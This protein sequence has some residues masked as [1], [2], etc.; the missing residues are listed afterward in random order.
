[1]NAMIG[2]F[3]GRDIIRKPTCPFCGAVISRPAEPEFSMPHDLPVG[4]C[5]CGATYAYDP[6]G[7]N[8]GIAMT[9]ALVLACGGD[10]DRAWDLVPDQDYREAQVENYDDMTHRVVPGGVYEGR[11][12]AGTLYFISMDREGAVSGTGGQETLMKKKTPS[13]R[14]SGKKAERKRFSKKEIE[15]LVDAY[16]TETIVALAR[17]DKRIIRD[18]QRLLYSADRLARFKAADLLGRA[19]AVISHDDPQ[20]ISKLLQGLFTSLLD[21]ASSSW[22]S[23]DAIGEIIYNRPHRFSGHIPQLYQLTRDR[24]L[25]GEVLHALARISEKRPEIMQK[26]AHQFIPLLGDPEPEN[27]A[28]TAMILGHLRFA[29]A[30]GHLSQMVDDSAQV[31]IYQGGAL[32]KRTVGQ[33]AEDAVKEL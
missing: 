21:T 8:L 10:W 33:V 27:R 3:Y 7:H 28:Y 16:D 32:H 22:G 24:A 1:M 4:T 12:I 23:L 19:A 20:S 15:S 6:T 9:D 14:P 17:Q 31:E 25:L 26:T 18:L 30:K 2:R 11:R 5:T 13:P 29:E